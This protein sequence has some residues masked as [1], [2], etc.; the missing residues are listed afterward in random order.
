MT[1][2]LLSHIMRGSDQAIRLKCFLSL[3]LSLSLSLNCVNV[4]YYN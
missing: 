4:F 1:K 3:S 2:V